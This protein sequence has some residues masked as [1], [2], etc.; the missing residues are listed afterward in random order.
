VGETAS[1][2]LLFAVV[3]AASPVALLATLAVL[4]SRRGRANGAAFVSGFVV[5]QA[6]A[7][8]AAVLVGS[9]ATV[10]GPRGNE[11]LAAG[12]ELAFGLGLLALAWPERRRAGR[13]SSGGPSRTERLL[14]RLKRLRPA[15]AFSVGTL[16][17]VGGVKRL[18]ITIVAGATV[19]IAGLLPVE[20]LLLGALYLLI[21]AV[22]VWLPVGVYLVAG[23]HADRW[24]SESEAW[25]LA[26]ERRLTFFSTL[27]FGFLLVSDALFRLL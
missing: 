24:M 23:D 2:V 17:G 3:A 9:A 4:T 21:A 22:L 7:F 10:D 6:V 19:G 16:L 18:S 20:E 13:A 8:L 15:T 5:G 27:F 25:L 14:A 26:N 1:R 12:L 11:E